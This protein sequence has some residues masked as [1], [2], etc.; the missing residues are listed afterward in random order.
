MHMDDRQRFEDA[1]RT[2]SAAVVSYVARRADP[3][4]AADVVSETFMTAWRRVADLPDADGQRA[5]LITIARNVLANSYRSER[6]RLRL[7]KKA[8]TE[9]ERTIRDVSVEPDPSGVGLDGAVASALDALDPDDRELLT[10]LAW[11]RLDRSEIAAVFECTSEALRTRIHRA[12]VRFRIALDQQ[13][14]PTPDQPASASLDP[15]GPDPTSN[16]TT[17]INPVLTMRSHPNV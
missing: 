3:T 16:T 12:R 6:R 1:Y 14:S 7:V 2:H 15:I 4:T 9:L 11:D 5:W 17:S 13:R 10:L 8:S